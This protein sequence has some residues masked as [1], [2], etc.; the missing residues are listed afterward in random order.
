MITRRKLATLFASAAGTLGLGTGTA[1]ATVRPDL[2]IEAS[3]AE[4]LRW[5][6]WFRDH[7]D[8]LWGTRHATKAELVSQQ[9]MKLSEPFHAAN[10]HIEYG[11][12]VDR[13]TD[14]ALLKVYHRDR[15]K[16]IEVGLAYAVTRRDIEDASPEELDNT[17]NGCWAALTAAVN[18][19]EAP[20][21]Y[22]GGATPML[23]MRTT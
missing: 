18:N 23:S 22:E 17:I 3:T 10:P 4:F 21:K 11:S 1:T 15:A 14:N 5:Q 8:L 13:T 19:G 7:P 9:A 12:W 2:A 6:Q 16:D 20:R